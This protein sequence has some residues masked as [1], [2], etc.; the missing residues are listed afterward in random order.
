MKTILEIIE[1]SSG[2]FGIYTNTPGNCCLAVGFNQYEAKQLALQIDALIANY[3][4][5][6]DERI[7]RE[8]EE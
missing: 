3:E 8:K 1:M 4:K 6:R 7:Q 5:A 2:G